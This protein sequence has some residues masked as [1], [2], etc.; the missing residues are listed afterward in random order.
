LSICGFTQP[1]KAQV[2]RPKGNRDHQ[3]QAPQRQRE[4]R[5]N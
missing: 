2:P 3:P 5:A 4:L 1:V